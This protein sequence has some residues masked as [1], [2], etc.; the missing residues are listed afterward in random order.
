MKRNTRISLFVIIGLLLFSGLNHC[1]KKP[2]P[3]KIS[4]KKFVQIYCD[5][6]CYSDIID[7]KLRKAMVD[8]VLK[9]YSVTQENFEYS[10]KL[11]SKDPEKWKNIFEKIVNELEQRKKELESKSDSSTVI[12]NHKKK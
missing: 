5:V 6:T 11:I 8:S 1:K 7:K 10:K 2:G 12:I 4:D 3:Q 9:S